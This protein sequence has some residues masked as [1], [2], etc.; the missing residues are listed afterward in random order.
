V[1][2]HLVVCLAATLT[3][4]IPFIAAE[5]KPS[6]SRPRALIV[7]GADVGA[8]DWRATTPVTRTIL[9]NAGGFQVFV[10]EDPGILESASSLSSYDVIVLNYRNA[11]ETRLGEAARKN[12]ISFVEG[13]KGLVAIHFVVNAWTDWD[14]FGKL[15]GRVWVGR[16]QGGE[17]VSGHGPRGTFQVRITDR[18]SPITKGIEDF[19]ADDELYARL[20]GDTPIHVLATAHSADYS[21]ADEPMAWTLNRGRG[22]VFVTVLGHDARSRENP[23]FG[24]LLAGGARW[25]AGVEPAR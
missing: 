2:R 17:K 4:V 6:P 24:K 10:C 13:G 9:E 1:I 3:A 11:P 22:R 20:A 5:E 16:R 12:L 7:T 15:I 23:A 14:E 19:E 25:A 21:K 8:H 18:E